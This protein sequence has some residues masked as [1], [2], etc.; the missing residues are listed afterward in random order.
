M[1]N[2]KVLTDN[3]KHVRITED[4]LKA[5]LRQQDICNYQQ[6]KAVVLESSGDISVIQ[7]PDAKV[8][9]DPNML[10]GVVKDTTK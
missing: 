10:D 8:S 4:E 2:G 5:K 6:I 9:F 7:N 1:H 3:L